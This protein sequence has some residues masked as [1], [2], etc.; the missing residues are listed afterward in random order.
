MVEVDEPDRDEVVGAD[1]ADRLLTPEPA[2]HPAVGLDE[3]VVAD[4]EDGGPQARQDL[5]DP[6]RLLGDGWVQPPERRDDLRLD[7]DGVVGPVEGPA[8]HEPP[9]E[10]GLGK[11]VDECGLD[12]GLGDVAHAAPSRKR[13]SA[14]SRSLIRRCSASG[15]SYGD[16]AKESS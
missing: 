16:R 13:S 3:P 9:A 5:V 15:G 1:E 2:G 8:G 4:R 7:E 10:V 6:L 12:C 14:L 11:P